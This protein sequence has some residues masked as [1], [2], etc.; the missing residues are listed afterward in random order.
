M[1]ILAAIYFAFCKLIAQTDVCH[2]SIRPFLKFDRLFIVSL[3]FW[4]L[5]GNKF[6]S[7]YGMQTILQMTNL[8]AGEN[9]AGTVH[10]KGYSSLFQCV[11]WFFTIVRLVILNF[12][13]SSL[14]SSLHRDK[15]LLLLG[16]LRMLLFICRFTEKLETIWTNC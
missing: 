15:N 8:W 14:P 10:R 13:H 7:M 5:K 4:N 6:T 12:T 9:F 11:F 3:I 2:I 16:T 1:V